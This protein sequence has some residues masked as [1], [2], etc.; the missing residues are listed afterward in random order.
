MAYCK[1]AVCMTFKDEH[2]NVKLFWG[3]FVIQLSYQAW[4]KFMYGFWLTVII[5]S[6][7]ILVLIYT[8][9]FDDF[10]HYWTD[11]LGISV[12]L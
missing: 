9:Q 4:R 10:P 5:Y 7:S 1:I 12:E 8:Y 3:I 6:M 11:Y 2:C